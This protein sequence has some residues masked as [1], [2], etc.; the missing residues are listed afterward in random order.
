[1]KYKI[2]HVNRIFIKYYSHN[3]HNF[4]KTNGREHNNK[5]YKAVEII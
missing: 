4:L 2:L 1:M 3:I 5:L